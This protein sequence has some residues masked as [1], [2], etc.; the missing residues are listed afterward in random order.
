MP[1]KAKQPKLTDKGNPIPVGVARVAEATRE[2]SRGGYAHTR[3]HLMTTFSISRATAERDIAEAYQ[4]M[5]SDAEAERPSLRARELERLTRIARAAEI[6]GDY[7][8]AIRAS[9][10]VAKICGLESPTTVNL[11]VAPEGQ[12]MLAALVM[13][14]HERRQRMAELA[15]T[16][17]P[18]PDVAG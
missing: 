2:L 10:Q 8:A 9:A 12:A 11:G 1:P 16:Q 7:S 15:A 14:P 4:L 18:K 6:A 13:T 17:A 5:A 3:S